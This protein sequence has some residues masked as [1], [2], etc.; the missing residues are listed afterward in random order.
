MVT[1]YIY[2]KTT[3]TTLLFIAE[4][5]KN[6]DSTLFVKLL[7]HILI[8]G[9]KAKCSINTHKFFKRAKSIEYAAVIGS[10][11]SENNEKIITYLC[12]LGKRYKMKFIILLPE[13]L[14]SAI[15]KTSLI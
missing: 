11:H 10:S 15:L 4:Q 7:F 3:T 8:I 9:I 1:K 13:V 6:T 12:N 14:L 5:H 2:S